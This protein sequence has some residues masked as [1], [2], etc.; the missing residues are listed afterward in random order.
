[1][2]KKDIMDDRSYV[3]IYM[4]QTIDRKAT[5]KFWRKPDVQQGILDYHK[6]FDDLKAQTF[7]LGHGSM[8]NSSNETPDLSKYKDKEKLEHKYFVVHLEKGAIYYY[9]AYD[10]KGTVGFKSNVLNTTEWL[11]DGSTILCKIIEVVT[12]EVSN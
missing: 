12:E 2:E 7:A 9:V 1:M 8:K 10:S 5:G 6:F 4:M 11:K 3:E